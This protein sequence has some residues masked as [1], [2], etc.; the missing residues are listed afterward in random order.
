MRNWLLRTPGEDEILP[1]GAGFKIVPFIIAKS[2][3][4]TPLQPE[5]T[6]FTLGQS[7]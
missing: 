1:I 5:Q 3:N 2:H 7:P 6:P 4:R